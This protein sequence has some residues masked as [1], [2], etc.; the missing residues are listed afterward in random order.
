MTEANWSVSEEWKL[1]GSADL[2]QV[3]LYA[4]VP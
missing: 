4:C 3:V 2:E 1:F